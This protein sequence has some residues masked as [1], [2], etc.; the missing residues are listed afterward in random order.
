MNAVQNYITSNRTALFDWLVI[1]LSFSLGF[2]FPDLKD[3]V[4]SPSLSYWMLAGLLLYTTGTLLKH[5][6]LSYRV[7]TTGENL[8]EVPY[9]IFLVLGH[10]IIIF[11]AMIFA[12]T[13][14]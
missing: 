10:W 5:R 14:V 9:M 12:E 6:P 13:A 3:L 11:T 8:R 2:I 1:G 7:T 4:T